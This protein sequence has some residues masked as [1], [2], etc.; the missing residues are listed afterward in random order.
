MK[1]KGQG[2]KNKFKLG[3]KDIFLYGFLFLFLLFLSF[4]LGAF[5]APSKTQTTIPLSQVINDVK[6]KKVK[7]IVVNEAKLDVIY[8]DNRKVMSRKEVGASMYTILSD[9]KVDPSSVKITIKDSTGFNTWVGVLTTFLP[10]LIIIGFFYFI[11]KQSKGAQENF[12]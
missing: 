6:S 1:I 9:A 12:F 8:S 2:K 4:G 10:V 7:E 3:W 5:S 11:F